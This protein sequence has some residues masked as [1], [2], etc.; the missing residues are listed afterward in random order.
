M[1]SKIENVSEIKNKLICFLEEEMDKGLS[2]INTDEAG[3]V[4]DMIKDLA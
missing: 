3:K 1:Y 4:I 2:C